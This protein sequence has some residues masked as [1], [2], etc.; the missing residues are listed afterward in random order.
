MLRARHAVYKVHQVFQVSQVRK[1]L[2]LYELD[3]L[4]E[5]EKLVTCAPCAGVLTEVKHFS[6]WRKE[7]QQL[8]PEYRREKREQPKLS[9]VHLIKL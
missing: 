8:F 9:K 2:K 6:K 3:G 1:V 5:L 7:E 4:D